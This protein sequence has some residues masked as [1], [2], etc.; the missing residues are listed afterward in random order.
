MY[1]NMKLRTEALHPLLSLYYHKE[2][3]IQTVFD[4]IL[5]FSS[6]TF[7]DCWLIIINVTCLQAEM[8]LSATKINTQYNNNP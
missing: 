5:S 7:I 1:N 2:I 4:I 8:S 6:I 3:H